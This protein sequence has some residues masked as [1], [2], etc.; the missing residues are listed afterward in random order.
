[1]VMMS[2]TSYLS[3]IYGSLL[4]VERAEKICVGSGIGYISCDQDR[5]RVGFIRR[6]LEKVLNVVSF[7]QGKMPSCS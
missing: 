4:G 2:D 7:V 5:V 1:M 3:H 6:G